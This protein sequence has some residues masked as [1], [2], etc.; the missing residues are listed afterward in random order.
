MVN[1][2]TEPLNNE[3]SDQDHEETYICFQGRDC[4]SILSS[5]AD[6]KFDTPR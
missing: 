3:A 1:V 6:C 2:Q 4:V 5:V